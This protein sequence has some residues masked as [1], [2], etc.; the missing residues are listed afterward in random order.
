MNKERIS[1]RIIGA[2]SYAVGL[3]MAALS[4][5]D[6]Y[7]VDGMVILAVLGN[8]SVLLGIDAYKKLNE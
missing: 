2:I 1:K 7:E 6:W 5:L 8:G 4:G 3:T